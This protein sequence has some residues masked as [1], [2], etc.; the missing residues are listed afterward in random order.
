MTVTR[1][2]EGSVR[3]GGFGPGPATPKPRIDPKGQKKSPRYHLGAAAAH[4]Y[5]QAHAQ[6]GETA[7]KTLTK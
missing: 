5:F 6:S 1:L 7:P 3:R 2:D 4:D